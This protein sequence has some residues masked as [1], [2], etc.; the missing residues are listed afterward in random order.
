MT[1]KRQ[2]RRTRAEWEEIVKRYEAS[3]Q[4]RAA[5]CLAEGLAAPTLDAYRPET[6]ADAGQLGGA[7]LGAP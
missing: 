5:F 1:S 3:E 6:N 7:P 2:V 4:S